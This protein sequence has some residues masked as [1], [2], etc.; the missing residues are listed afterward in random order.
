MD[1]LKNVNINVNIV[2]QNK[3]LVEWFWNKFNSCYLVK[4]DD[5]PESI[6]MYYDPQYIR[7]LKL[8]NI[9][10]EKINK[11]DI[12][13]TCLFDINWKNK[14]L[15]CDHIEIWDYLYY[16]YSHNYCSIRQFISDRLEEYFKININIE[17]RAIFL[18]ILEKDTKMRVISPIVSIEHFYYNKNLNKQI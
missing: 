2:M 8:S 4:H 16:N 17:N 14:K 7:K 18:Y 3:D 13:G 12:T 9:S 15:Y 11:T 1:R 10:G 6:F 5:Y